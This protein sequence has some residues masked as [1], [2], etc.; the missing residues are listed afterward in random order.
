MPPA[1][2]PQPQPQPMNVSPTP[3]SDQQ[4]QQNAS[5]TCRMVLPNLSFPLRSCCWHGSVPLRISSTVGTRYEHSFMYSNGTSGIANQPQNTPQAGGSGAVASRGIW[6]KMKAV[7]SLASSLL[8]RR[9]KMVKDKL[10]AVRLRTRAFV[11]V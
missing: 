11:M 5:K 6:T 1:Q 8:G 2:D 3:T 4:L 10:S 7:V 9:L